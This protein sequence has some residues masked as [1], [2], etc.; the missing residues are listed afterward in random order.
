MP[1]LFKKF[2]MIKTV[3][4]D[5]DGTLLDVGESL[6]W[7][8][9]MLTREFNGVQASREAIT[10]ALGASDEHGMRQL[11]TNWRVPAE[12]IRQRHDELRVES[13][14]RMQTY[15]QAAEL[16]TTLRERG[17]RIG[18]LALDSLDTA[19][20][21]ARLGLLPHI[22]AIVTP[23]HLPG[24]SRT[25]GVQ[26]LLRQLDTL[27]YEA[28]MV[29]DHPEDIKAGKQ[30][31]VYTTIGVT[32]GFGSPADLQAAGADHLV[33]DMPTLLSVLG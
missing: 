2:D 3:I 28:I 33:H 23:E 16:L 14:R 8:Y 20:H 21:L 7:Q 15:P 10:A 11:I 5:L 30:A 22:H 9:E 12:R 6:F 18:V 13:L 31:G 27:P 24:R 19:P 26:T 4:F 25:T 32:H 1:W 29:G 17:V